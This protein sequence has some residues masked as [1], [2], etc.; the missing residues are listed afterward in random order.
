MRVASVP[1]KVVPR[2]QPKPVRAQAPAPQKAVQRLAAPTA[3]AG[4]SR[5]N[6]ALIGVFGAESGRHALLRLPNGAVQR[7]RAGDSVQGVQV[8]AVGSD[9]VR[10][11]GRGRDTLLRLPD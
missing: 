8:A 6:V 4:L 1:Q 5:G 7:V 2:A 11:S 3:R 9:S 10:L